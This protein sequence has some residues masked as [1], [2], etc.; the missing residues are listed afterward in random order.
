MQ[1][2]Y[3]VVRCAV[4]SEDQDKIKHE[5]FKIPFK[6]RKDEEPAE[7]SEE[8]TQKQIQILSEQ[9][10]ARAVAS[11][12]ASIKVVQKPKEEVKN[13]FWEDEPPPIYRAKK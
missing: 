4:R 5:Q 13:T 6:F 8:E 12:G 3:E 2:A 11:M 9:A 10:K 1:I 7:L